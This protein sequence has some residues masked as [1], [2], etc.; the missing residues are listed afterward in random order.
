MIRPLYASGRA[1]RKPTYPF[2]TFCSDTAE[3]V[4]KGERCVICGQEPKD[5]YDQKHLDEFD[6]ILAH[7]MGRYRKI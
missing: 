4:V 5:F 7:A 3:H 2:I 1:M 6:K